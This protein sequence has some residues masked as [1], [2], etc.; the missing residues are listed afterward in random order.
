[1]KKLALT[2]LVAVL[3][4]C[5]PATTIKT[6]VDAS[7]T[8]YTLQQGGVSVLPTGLGQ[9]VRDAN[10]P[11]LRRQLAQYVTESLNKALVGVPTKPIGETYD[12]LQK[13]SLIDSYTAVLNGFDQTGLL[14]GS[15][16]SE[17]AKIVGTR[18]LLIPYLQSAVSRIV[19]SGLATSAI[20]EA[21]FTYII[22][23]ANLEK[24]VFEGSG[25]GVTSRSIFGGGNIIDAIYGSVDQATGKLAE[26]VG[27]QT[28]Q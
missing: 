25:A 17:I 4:A 13:A 18:Y 27:A 8:L 6:Y 24:S 20:S 19:Y 16:M 5:V 11:E 2:I 28:K 1:M 14:N 23:D 10:L 9:A 7:L 21:A 15:R 26:I 22:W 12:A 3:V